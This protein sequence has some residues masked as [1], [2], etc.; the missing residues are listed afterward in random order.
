MGAQT[1]RAALRLKALKLIFEVPD[2]LQELTV[3]KDVTSIAYA[4]TEGLM[5]GSYRRA[6]YK[7]VQS[8]YTGPTAVVFT[9]K[10]KLEGTAGRDW[11]QGIQ[12]GLAFG[13][14]TNLARSLT[15]ILW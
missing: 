13:E 1:V 14:A 10:E 8:F 15:N 9:I 2:K 7:Q 3:E 12:K 5:L 11:T 6:T 4:L